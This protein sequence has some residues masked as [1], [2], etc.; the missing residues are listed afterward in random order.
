MNRIVYEFL[1]AKSEITSVKES[2]GMIKG[3]DIS[4]FV[5]RLAPCFF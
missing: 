3:P 5:Q 1:P 4:Y 2:E